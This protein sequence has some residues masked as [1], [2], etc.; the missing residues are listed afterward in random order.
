MNPV[1]ERLRR[2]RRALELID[3]AGEILSRTTRI[4]RRLMPDR[5]TPHGFY[6]PQGFVAAS[7]YHSDRKRLFK[8]VQPR[9][10]EKVRGRALMGVEPPVVLKERGR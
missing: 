5:R 1:A 10:E 4:V 6:D 9:I 3:E 7:N 8:Q 2:S